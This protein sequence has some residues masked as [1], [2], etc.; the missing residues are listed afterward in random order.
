LGKPYESEL[1]RLSETL[2][3]AAQQDI[4]GFSRAILAASH[5][6]LVAIGSGGSLSA[7]TFACFLHR[8]FFGMLAHPTTPYKAADNVSRSSS[9]LLIS[10]RGGNTDVLGV[11]R[12][13]LEAEPEAFSILCGSRESDLKDHAAKYEMC[14]YFG[15]DIPAGSDGFVATNSLFAAILLLW[16]AY[17]GDRHRPRLQEFRSELTTGIFK[18]HLDNEL[19]KFSKLARKQYFVVL[20]GKESECAA[21][22]IES[23]FS[24]VGLGSAQLCDFRNFAHGRHNWLDKLGDQTALITFETPEDRKLAE[25]TLELIPNRI[26]RIRIKIPFDAAAAGVASIF[27]G[28]HLVRVAGKARGLDPGRPGVPRYGSR[29]YRLNAWPKRNRATLASVAIER[30]SGD[31]VA[32]LARCEK[33]D[34]WTK[35]FQEVVSD[36]T[37]AKFRSMIFDY[38]GTLCSQ[39]ERLAG[40]RPQVVNELVRLVDCGVELGIAT[41]RGESVRRDLQRHL[42]ERLWSKM[43]VA[44]H[45]GDEIARLEDSGIPSVS[46]TTCPELLDAAKALS[47]NPQLNRIAAVKVGARQVTVEPKVEGQPHFMMDL[48][49]QI[50]ARIP[51]ND[52]RVVF[53]TRSVDVIASGVSKLAIKTHFSSGESLCIGD[54]GDWPGNDF[55][56]LSSRYSLSVDKVSPDIRTGWNL[57][58]PGY[59]GVQTTLWYLSCITVVG[60]SASFYRHAFDKP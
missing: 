10:A 34:Y 38:D 13:I 60:G 47:E 57:G 50:L 1:L 45:N 6:P 58:P 39:S 14:Q 52:V 27:A 15:F 49:Q 53:S 11:T 7:A 40:L 59:R 54:L 18:K 56:L 41:G 46:R 22:D 2:D 42:P 33:L 17:T 8:K 31:S 23:K 28:L 37:E 44:Y 5:L 24:E 3:W 29:L 19:A 36:L 32:N 20:H 43:L 26:P 48:V 21:I 4:A 16:R 51:R 35:A 55:E 12:K 30:K 25:R 9:V